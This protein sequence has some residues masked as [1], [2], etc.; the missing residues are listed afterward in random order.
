MNLEPLERGPSGRIN[1]LRIEGTL[2]SGVIGKELAIRRALSRSHLKSSDFEVVHEDGRFTLRGKGWGHGV[3]LCQIGAAV[4][5]SEG[6]DYIQ[7]LKHYY[8]GTEIGQ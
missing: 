8:V 1:Y 3:G 7:I 6:Y 4:M 5:A 2:R